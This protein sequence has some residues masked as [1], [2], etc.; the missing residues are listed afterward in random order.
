MKWNV[1]SVV[2]LAKVAQR[3]RFWALAVIIGGLAGATVTSVSAQEL[4]PDEVEFF[5]SKI[6]PVLIEHCHSCHSGDTKPKPKGGLYLDSKAGMIK[7]GSSGP[8]VVA[9]DPSKSTFIKRLRLP[10]TNDEVMPPGGKPRLSPEQ[11]SDLEQWV[12]MGAPDPRTGKAAGILKGADDLEKA[13]KHWAFQPVKK[14][15]IPVPQRTVKS[16]IKSP[17]DAFIFTKMEEKGII[18]SLPA[19][20]WTLIRRAYFDIIGI[21][22]T[23]EEAAAFIADESPDAFSKVIDRLL[24]SPHYCERWGRYWLDVARYADTTGANNRR[25]GNGRYLWAYTYRDYVIHALNED[26]PYDRFLIEQLAADRLPGDNQKALPALGFISLGRRDRNQDEIIDDR[27]DVLTRGTLGLSVYCARCHDH[28]FDPIPTKDYYSLYG[29]FASTVEPEDRPK[30][31]TDYTPGSSAATNPDYQ[32]FQKKVDDIEKDRKLFRAKTEFD[33]QLKART[34]SVKYMGQWYVQKTSG[35]SLRDRADRDAFERATKLDFEVLQSWNNYLGKKKAD[36]PVFAHFLAYAAIP[37][38]K[39]FAAEAKLVTERLAAEAA[40]PAPLPASNAK[41]GAAPQK[42]AS[43]PPNPLVASQFLAKSPPATMADVVLRY[44][45]VIDAADYHWNRALAAYYAANPG[46]KDESIKPPTDLMDAQK[47]FGYTVKGVN[48]ADYEPLRTVL[49]GPSSPSWFTYGQIARMDNNRIGDREGRDFDDKID[50]LIVTHPGSPPRAMSMEDSARPSNARVFIKGSRNNLGPEAPRQ[51]LEVLSGPARQPFKDGSGRLELAKAV[52]SKENPLTARVMVNRVWMHHFGAG[53]VRNMGDFG[54]RSD[55][56]THPELLDYLAAWFMDNGWSLKKLHKFIM[57]SNTYQQS[58]DENPRYAAVDPSNA[59]FYKFNRRRLDFEAFRD[60]LL[61]VSGKIDFTMGG[62]PVEITRAPYPLRRS[63]YAFIDRRNLPEMFRTFDMANPEA[64]VA[65]RFSS[66]VP[67]QALFMLNSPIIAQLARGLVEKKEFKDFR[68]DQQRIASLYASIYQRSPEPVEMKLGIR[69]LEE[70]SGEKSEAVPESQ[71]KYGYGNYDEVGKK[72][73]RLHVL[74]HYT[75]TS[76][77]GSGRLPDLQYG[78]LHLNAKGGHPGPIPQLA[79]IRR[80]TAPRDMTVDIEGTL[81]HNLDEKARE[82]VAKLPKAQRDALDKVYDGVNGFILHT[83]AG[84]PKEIWRGS[85]RRG[86]A[87][88]AAPG[89]VV[90][91]NDTIDFVVHCNK[92]PHQDFFSWAPVVKITGMKEAMAPDPKTGSMVMNE[93]KAADDFAPP[94]SKPK[95][96][97]VW[98]KYAQ[99]LLLTNEMTYVD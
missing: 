89:V 91:K 5:E 60:S 65:Q 68:S 99:T 33:F 87:N 20:K 80:W 3:C 53:I 82:I 71:W 31:E 34:N 1:V 47:R 39:N 49:Y 43:T 37:T 55:D 45:A 42:N 2:S 27:I 41:K 67:Q 11:L 98:E 7:G 74:Q 70:E 22:P 32:D 46:G 25:G 83:A 14:P 54:V 86:S 30:I 85:A 62:Q 36:D 8:V 4:R 64:T 19:D 52:A 26:K 18:P 21:P 75:G 50:T 72:L 69:F 59:S 90:K 51:F 63:V 95:P 13:K 17:I 40:V 58:S 6:R 10:E 61:F 28:K 16:W 56:P 78:N 24:D 96:L 73:P 76:W 29:V 97:N 48:L 66:T 92:Q 57:L 12:R 93:W 77:Q 23:P 88:A 35:K 9:G 84:V 94:S 44:K 81:D 38:N 15:E 79:A